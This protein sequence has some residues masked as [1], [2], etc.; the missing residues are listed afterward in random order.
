MNG[1]FSALV[2]VMAVLGTPLFIVI[3]AAAVVG[4]YFAE[5]PLTVIAVEIYRIVDTPL[6]LA[7]PLFTM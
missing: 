4:F 7:L 1:I 2:G 5:I 6:L 3:L